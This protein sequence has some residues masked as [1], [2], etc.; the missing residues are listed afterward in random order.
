LVKRNNRRRNAS[1]AQADLE[2]LV[3]KKPTRTESIDLS[4]E[5]RAFL[6][7]PN[8]ITED[9]ADAIVAERI[10]RR[11]GHKTKPIR[12]YLKERGIKLEG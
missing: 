12:E 10:Y 8:W 6:D 5:E 11:E 9:E 3:I 4:D 1:Y 7:D 2:E